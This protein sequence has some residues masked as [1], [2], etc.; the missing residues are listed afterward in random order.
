M[1]RDR[2]ND[3]NRYIKD[4]CEADQYEIALIVKRS[5]SLKLDDTYKV[6][7]EISCCELGLPVQVIKQRLANS[8]LDLLDVLCRIISR[9]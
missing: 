8:F 1:E 7:K 2:I 4:R 6:I 9:W 5:K 3:Y